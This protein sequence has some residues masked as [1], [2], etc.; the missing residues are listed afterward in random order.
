MIPLNWK[1]V[2]GHFEFLISLMQEANKW[3]NNMLILIAFVSQRKSGYY[4][5]MEQ[6]GTPEF[7]YIAH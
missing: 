2:F 4:F 3:A 5:F 6:L 1:L 7:S